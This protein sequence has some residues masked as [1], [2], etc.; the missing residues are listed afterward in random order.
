MKQ[1]RVTFVQRFT[2]ERSVFYLE[3]LNKEGEYITI[4]LMH[5]LECYKIKADEGY[6]IT[7]HYLALSHYQIRD[8]QM[9]GK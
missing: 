1:L 2:G 8:V 9:V 7:E 5:D 4:E 6:V 3:P